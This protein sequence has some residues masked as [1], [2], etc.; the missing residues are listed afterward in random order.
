[1]Y[2]LLLISIIFL[3]IRHDYSDLSILNHHVSNV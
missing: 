2:I 3:Y 1:M